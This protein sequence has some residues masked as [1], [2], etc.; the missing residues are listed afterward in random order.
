ME[1]IIFEIQSAKKSLNQKIDCF[2]QRMKQRDNIFYLL[3]G[4]IILLITT[5]E[6]LS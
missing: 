2:E 3:L 6:L 4:V 5:L 1:E